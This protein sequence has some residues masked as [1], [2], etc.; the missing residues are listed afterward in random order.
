MV[1]LGIGGYDVVLVKQDTSSNLGPSDIK[2][3]LDDLGNQLFTGTCNF[4]PL[5]AK[6]KDNKQKVRICYLF[7]ILFYYYFFKGKRI[8]RNIFLLSIL[9]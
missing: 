5:T 3:H 9:L 8:K 1:G 6:T 2:K 4:T 7:F